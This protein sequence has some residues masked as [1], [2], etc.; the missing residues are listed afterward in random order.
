M[1]PLAYGGVVDSERLVHGLKRLSVA[2]ISAWT[3]TPSSAPSVTLYA[4][5]DKVSN[6][7]VS[8]PSWE[9]LLLTL[10]TAGRHYQEATWYCN[11]QPWRLTSLT[12]PLL[13]K[14][15]LKIEKG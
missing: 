9:H 7:N 14:V 8:S 6:I 13:A 15:S 2:D 1:L 4:A 3:F 12:Q 5:G 10:I 11:L